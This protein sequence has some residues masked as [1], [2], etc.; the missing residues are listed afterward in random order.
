MDHW[1]EY[2][3]GAAGVSDPGLL[4]RALDRFL[5]EEVEAVVRLFPSI[6]PYQLRRLCLFLS[7]LSDKEAALLTGDGVPAVRVARWRFRQKLAA[8]GPEGRRLADRMARREEG[9]GER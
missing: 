3:F 8:A 2:A 6:R 7:G 5:G 9:G 4:G 1:T